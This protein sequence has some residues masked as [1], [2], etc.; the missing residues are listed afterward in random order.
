MKCLTV[1][2]YKGKI[3]FFLVAAAAVDNMS[4]VLHSTTNIYVPQ[5]FFQ[6]LPILQRNYQYL[7]L[8]FSTISQK[9]KSFQ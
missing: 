2:P 6:N 1:T 8:L 3:I 4:A 9:N 5:M 7:N